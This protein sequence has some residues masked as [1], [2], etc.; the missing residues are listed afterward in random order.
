MF[1]LLDHLAFL[2]SL[3]LCCIFW[4]SAWIGGACVAKGKGT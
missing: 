4:I 1:N 2:P 3:F